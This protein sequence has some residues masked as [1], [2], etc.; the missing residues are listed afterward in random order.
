[1]AEQQ[2][3]GYSENQL[4]Q[5][6]QQSEKE[7]SQTKAMLQRVNML[8]SET[9]T[10]KEGLKE[11]QKTSGKVLVSVGSG[12]LVEVEAKKIEKCKRAFGEN[13]YKEESIPETLEW[14][15]KREEQLKKQIEELTKEYSETEQRLTTMVGILK[16]IDSEKRKY[17]SQLR[18]SPPTISK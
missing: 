3:Q 12:V 2:K 1:M 5:I 11:M 17:A 4:L 16:Q 9:V 10:A 7:L 6:A 15:S 8:Y 18:N 13:S 14:L